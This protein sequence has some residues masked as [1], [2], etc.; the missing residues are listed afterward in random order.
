MAS[1]E[2]VVRNM[3]FATGTSSPGAAVYVGD[4]D[5]A[6]V[7]LQAGGTF[8]ATVQFQG[9]LDK[10]VWYSIGNATTI[11]AG[12]LINMSTDANHPMASAAWVRVQTPSD[13]TS[14]SAPVCTVAG[15][16]KSL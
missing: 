1:K 15:V 16:P 8:D 5:P 2:L 12:G 10:Q 4:L 13:F 9:S 6:T 14:A 7:V 3:P 11:D